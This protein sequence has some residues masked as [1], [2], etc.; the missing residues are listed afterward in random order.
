[1]ATTDPTPTQQAELGVLLA[2][3]VQ[4]V[5]SAQ[6]ALDEHARRRGEDYLAGPP[7]SLVLPPL[8]YAFDSVSI[9]IELSSEVVATATGSRL[10]CRTLNPTTVGLFG[11]SAAT[12]TRV[13]L[14][15][16]PQRLTPTALPP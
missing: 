15:L 5:V 1:M 10:V 7:G 13:R 16:S 12:G 6:D 4:G 14:T 8:W 9:D 3:A 2:G 11:Y